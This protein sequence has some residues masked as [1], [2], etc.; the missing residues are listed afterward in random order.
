MG[1]TLQIVLFL[2]FYSTGLAAGQEG[3]VEPSTSTELDMVLEGFDDKPGTAGENQGLEDVLKGFED[4]ADGAD[5]TK[6]LNEVLK[7]FDEDDSASKGAVKKEGPKRNPFLDLSGSISL[8]A[9]YGYAHEDPKPG[10]ADYD[11]LSR[12]RSDLHLA[13]D[14]VFS[15]EWKA[16]ISGRAF[17]DLAYEINGRDQYGSEVLDDY[18][19]EAEFQEVY[20]QGPLFPNLDLK[21]GRQIVVWGKSDNIRVVDVLNPLD[22]REPGLVDIEDLRL[23]VAMSKLDY[24]FGQWNLSGIAV[25][26]IRFNKNPVFGSEFFSF[27]TPLPEEK[28]PADTFEN[29]E[30][31]LALNGILKGWDISFYGARFFDDQPH[32]ER[33]SPRQLERRHSRISMV[34]TS[35][36][37]ALGNW[38][39]KSEVAYF[40]GLQ[41]FASPGE[42]W[43]RFD[44]LAGVEYAGFTNTALS[45]EAVNRHIDDFDP[46]LEAPPDSARENEFQT[47]LRYM[48]DFR[49]DTLH[50]LILASTFGSS[51]D[52]GKFQRFSVEY[53]V[54]DAFSLKIGLVTYQSGDKAQFRSIGDNDRF[55]LE[56]KYSF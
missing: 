50:L 52:D 17:F 14:I 9:S 41:F 34:G 2:I 54:S 19:K 40:D 39:L 42:K 44:V 15:K 36:N 35:I 30:Y 31:A 18:E 28:E 10:Q 46:G 55:F 12:L 5:E 49:H 48:G 51:G 23:P 13:L 43:S 25:H 21:V 37:V 45:L 22:N 53:D 26:E 7:G 32:V 8:G 33:V 38:L 16:L 20:L 4:K 47:V 11:G 56:A 1:F 6:D 3:S 29:T 27:E 24:Y